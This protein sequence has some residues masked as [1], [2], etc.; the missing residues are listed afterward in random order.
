MRTSDSEYE[1]RREAWVQKNLAHAPELTSEQ[2]DLLR[3]VFGKR[4]GKKE[5]PA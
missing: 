4:K 5:S 3:R 2:R 1:R